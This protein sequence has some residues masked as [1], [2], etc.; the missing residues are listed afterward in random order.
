MMS[1]ELNN[2]VAQERLR[3]K[4]SEIKQLWS[5]KL[6]EGAIKYDPSNTSVRK[7]GP[8]SVRYLPG[9]LQYLKETA[10]LP[11]TSIDMPHDPQDIFCRFRDDINQGQKILDLQIGNS[12]WDLLVN[13]NPI[14]AFHT[15]LV[16]QGEPSSQ[17]I[18]PEY[19]EDLQKLVAANPDTTLA[20]NTFGAAASQNHFHIHLFFNNWSLDDIDRIPIEKRRFELVDTAKANEYLESLRNANTPYNL[21]MTKDGII[22][23]PRDKEHINGIKY[24]VDAISGRFPATSLD[25]FNNMTHGNIEEILKQIGFWN[26]N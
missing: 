7:L 22:I 24:G 17:L 19:L 16:P 23:T 26:G 3:L 20:F 6:H 14:E 9:R 8:Y 25:Q 2:G 13:N 12:R 4:T 15:M 18:R 5:Q 21:V 11:F 10:P 1:G